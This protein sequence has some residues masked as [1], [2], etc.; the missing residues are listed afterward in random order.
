MKFSLIMFLRYKAL[1]KTK[2]KK[3]E[4]KNRK[5]KITHNAF[6]KAKRAEINEL[7]E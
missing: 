1:L 2:N 5:K 3:K 7:N 4:N 6:K